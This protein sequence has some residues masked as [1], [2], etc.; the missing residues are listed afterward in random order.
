ML[1]RACWQTCEE[2]R[3]E[4]IFLPSIGNLLFAPL[5]A[6]LAAFQHFAF[7]PAPLFWQTGDL[8]NIRVRSVSAIFCAP[9]FLALSV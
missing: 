9:H 2:H 8:P 3:L 4:R 6:L 1:S 7:L 5:L